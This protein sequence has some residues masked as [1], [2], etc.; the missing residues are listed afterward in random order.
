[1]RTLSSRNGNGTGS[2]PA[3]TGTRSPYRPTPAIRVPWPRHAGVSS[4]PQAGLIVCQS[5]AASAGSISGWVRLTP[6]LEPR[7]ERQEMIGHSTSSEDRRGHGRPQDSCQIADANALPSP[8]MAA[9]QRMGPTWL[10]V[11]WLGRCAQ[12]VGGIVPQF[13]ET[14]APAINLSWWLVTS[15]LSWGNNSQ[16]IM[17]CLPLR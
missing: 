5:S 4:L 15:V 12:P 3:S 16:G 14:G 17:R 6:L 11:T 7:R 1:M 8:S 2:P 9:L 10:S 13:S